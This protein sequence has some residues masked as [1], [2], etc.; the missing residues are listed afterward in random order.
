M[1]KSSRARRER[2]SVAHLG[3]VASGAL[4][5]GKYNDAIQPLLA[6]V[7]LN[8]ADPKAL[9]DLGLAYLNTQRGSEAIGWLRR[10][11]TAQ[12][13]DGAAYYNL[14]LALQ[15][16]GDD[17]AAVSALRGACALSPTLAVAHEA[18]ADLL[19]SLGKRTEAAAAYGRA[20]AA[21]PDT[22][23][24]SLSGA[25]AL[26]IGGRAAEAETE[27]RRITECHVAFGKAHVMLG[28][29]LQQAGRFI[30]AVASFER[31]LEI[32]PLDVTAY[33]GLLSSRRVTD[34]DRPRLASL[35]AL[36]K[37]DEWHRRFPPALADR[38][39]MTMHFALGKAHE[40]LGDYAVAM[41]NFGSA[42]RIR[43]RLCPFDYDG[44]ARRVE[45]TISL[46]TR[47]IFAASPTI[48]EFRRPT[49]DCVR[50]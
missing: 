5:A 45:Q 49:G 26:D 22:P 17:E 29:V 12:P 39:Q 1:T 46:F 13:G 20:A 4:K 24:G 10:L 47:D 31:A 27:L 8:P 32:D 21:A 14:G 19:L 15:Q 30:E 16:A 40:D 6:I 28:R 35:D 44:A 3:E 9:N 34:D 50:V 18:L 33:A 42:N 43:R 25:I 23:R 36:L 2:V 48:L 41:S 7:R 37:A 11:I 38:Y